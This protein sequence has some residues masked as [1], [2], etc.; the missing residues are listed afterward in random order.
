MDPAPLFADVADGPADGAAWWVTARDDLRLRVGLWN[1]EAPKGTVLIFPGRTEYVEKYGRAARALARCGYASLAIDWRGQGLA[2]RLLDDVMSGHVHHFPDYQ[3]DVA[4]M[5][6]TAARLD[7]P[8][9]WY[10]LAHS[11][12]GCIGLRAVM[13]GLDVQGCAFSSPMWGIKMA[14]ALRPVAWWLAWGSHQVGLSHRYAPGT[15]ADHYVLTEPFE[16]NKLTGDRDMWQYM[17]RQ[18]GAHPELGLGGP[19]LRWLYEA[20]RETR[21]LAQRPSPDL[22]C[23]TILGTDEDIVDVPRVTDRM[24]RWPRGH[25]EMVQG[26]RHET[27]M[28]GEATQARLFGL[29]CDFFERSRE[30]DAVAVS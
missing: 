18:L 10:L 17:A 2:D 6:E 12:G 21:A 28:E 20:L 27:L 29:L 9:P 24:A 13:D 5:T 11:M 23:L 22:P 1:R 30:K 8:R 3:Y 4:A 26:G 19:S 7:L 15:T 14:E 25:L 16:T